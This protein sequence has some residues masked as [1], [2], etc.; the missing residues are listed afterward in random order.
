[1]QDLNSFVL[2]ARKVKEFFEE[3]EQADDHGDIRID[4]LLNLRQ[5]YNLFVPE[6][7]FIDE[8][9]REMIAD[10]NEIES[11]KIEEDEETAESDQGYDAEYLIETEIVE[12][13][14]K[15]S[16][17]CEDFFQTAKSSPKSIEEFKKDSLDEEIVHFEDDGLIFQEVAI[18]NDECITVRNEEYEDN[19][20]SHFE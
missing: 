5:S 7:E 9:E 3:L 8:S 10:M 2:K 13:T 4:K 20:A 11:Y 16:T 19:I 6:I 17:D 14:M 1:M 18:E 12:P 15:D